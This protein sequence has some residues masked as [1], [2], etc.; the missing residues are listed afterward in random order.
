M[1]TTHVIHY[2]TVP[3][4]RRRFRR[5]VRRLADLARP[6]PRVDIPDHLRRDIGLPETR[7]GRANAPPGPNPYWGI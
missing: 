7:P 4:W 2:S 3:S 5:A 1:Q 6:R